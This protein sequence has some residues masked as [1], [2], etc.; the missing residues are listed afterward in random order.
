[1]PIRI[2]VVLVSLL[3]PW[4]HGVRILQKILPLPG[5]LNPDAREI[6]CFGRVLRLSSCCNARERQSQCQNED[7]AIVLH[8]LRTPSDCDTTVASLWTGK[9]FASQS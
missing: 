9:Y 4:L 5:S 1:M 2:Q 7:Y 6:R 3:R 8:H